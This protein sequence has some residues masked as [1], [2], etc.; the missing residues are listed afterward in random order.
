MNEQHS[1]MAKRL[2][3]YREK[4][5]L[6]QEK[7]GENLGVTQS[8][9][10][11]QEAGLV[12]VTYKNLKH[13]CENG[14]DA[15]LL[16]LGQPV[17]H[18]KMDEYM[19]SCTTF[20]GKKKMFEALVWAVDFGLR[21]MQECEENFQLTENTSKCLKFIQNYEETLTVWENIKET[22][23][24]SQEK[25]AKIFDI[26]VKRYRNI[27]KE[28]SFPDAEILQQLYYKLHYSPLLILEKEMYY[29]DE[30]NQAWNVFSGELKAL[31]ENRL[32]ADLALIKMYEE[33]EQHE[34]HTDSGR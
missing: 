28:I 12:R 32:D 7:M 25:I 29:L 8:H 21:Y 23:R 20:N 16:L 27:E 15:N 22:E 24:S 33:K 30:L 3:E 14:E 11:K 17:T 1:N 10:C 6:T 34:T 5:Q 26:N 13:F 19:N 18:G 31:L 4:M 2:Q 9:Y